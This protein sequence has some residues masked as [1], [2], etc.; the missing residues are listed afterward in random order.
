MSG[1]NSRPDQT[2]QGKAPAESGDDETA[3]FAGLGPF[4]EQPDDVVFRAVQNLVIRQEQLAKNRYAQ[5]DY[6]TQVKQGYGDYYKLEKLPDQDRWKCSIAPGI[7]GM[8]LAPVPNKAAD[9]CHKVVEALMVDPPKP[10]PKA[11]NDS[12]KAERGR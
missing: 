6:W 8:S 1:V 4:L 10:S 11:E 9:L 5:D 3:Q 2:P 7:A 12:E